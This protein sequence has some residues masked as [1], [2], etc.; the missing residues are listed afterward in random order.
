MSTAQKMS[1]FYTV[2]ALEEPEFTIV[3]K[4]LQGLAKEKIEI[5]ELSLEEAEQYEE[6]FEEMRNGNY[7]TLDDIIKKR[8][9]LENE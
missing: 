5:E 8:S 7:V 3:W 4:M 9:L 1:L 2:S 6:G